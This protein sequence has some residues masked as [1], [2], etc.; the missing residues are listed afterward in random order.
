M[1]VE[2]ADMKVEVVVI[3]V[4]DVDRSK[5]FYA[6]LGWRLDRTPPGVVQFTPHGSA[7]S[8]QF[9][10]ALTT[11][12]PGSAKAYLIVPDIEVTRNAL[13]DSG[14][15]VSEIFHPSP[16]GP[17]AGLDPERRSYYS[18]ATFSDPD[19]NTWLLQEITSR[20]PGRVDPGPTAFGSVS[21]L[22][23]AMRRAAV[24]H[25][26]HEKRTGEEDPN[27]PDWYA[28]YMANEQTG[29]EPPR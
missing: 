19:G 6:G 9:G 25:G 18:R 21:D 28:Q 12:A 5:E 11:A 8:V 3:P 16:D 17:V 24:A 1:D 26:E 10:P 22:A 23:N 20:L 14:V 2:D 4:A 7:C 15:E 13:V 29:A 27:W